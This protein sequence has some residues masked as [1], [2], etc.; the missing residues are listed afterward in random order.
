MKMKQNK[1]EKSSSSTKRPQQSTQILLRKFV[2][3]EER[4]MRSY[5]V[6]QVGSRLV[7]G[8]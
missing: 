6:R 7:G 5:Y 3:D 1:E 8:V 2:G 4:C